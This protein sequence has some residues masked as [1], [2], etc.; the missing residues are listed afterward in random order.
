MSVPP[1][2]PHACTARGARAREI[3]QAGRD[4]QR[5]E[6]IRGGLQDDSQHRRHDDGR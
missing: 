4:D 1:L 5:G 3:A 2:P 6:D